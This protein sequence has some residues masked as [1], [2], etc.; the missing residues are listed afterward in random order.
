M[1]PF[2]SIHPTSAPAQQMGSTGPSTNYAQE[3]DYGSVDFG[4]TYNIPSAWVP[5]A[6]P[7]PYEGL[8]VVGIRYETRIDFNE[9]MGLGEDTILIEKHAVQ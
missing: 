2:S 7:P 5:I 6:V 1:A 8:P 4:K 9:N 3:K